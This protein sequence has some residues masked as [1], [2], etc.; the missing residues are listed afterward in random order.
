M[1]KLC[2]LIIPVTFKDA[3][4]CEPLMV[5]KMQIFGKN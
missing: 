2:K 3:I 1:I 5:N 4:G